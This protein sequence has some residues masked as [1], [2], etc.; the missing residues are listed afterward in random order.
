VPL[1]GGDFLSREVSEEGVSSL[2]LV[3]ARNEVDK[4][5]VLNGN[6]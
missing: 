5:L 4:N 3:I 6:V 1:S 2:Q